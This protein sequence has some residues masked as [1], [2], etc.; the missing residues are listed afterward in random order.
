MLVVFECYFVGF[1]VNVR[2]FVI[3]EGGMGWIG[4]IVVYLYL[5]GL[6]GVF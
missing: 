5:V 1:M 4:V 6:N 2:F 3:F